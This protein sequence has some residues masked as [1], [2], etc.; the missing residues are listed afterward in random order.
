MLGPMQDDALW[1]AYANTRLLIG[2]AHEIKID[3]RE[4]LSDDLRRLLTHLGLGATFAIVTSFDP[5]GTRAPAMENEARH[6]EMRA[7]LLSRNLKFVPADGES[8]DSAHR[9]RGFAIAMSRGD[10]AALARELEQ[11]ALYW[12]DGEAFWID[13]ALSARAPRKLP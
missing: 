9:E 2:S 13:A 1:S 4:P 11:L 8:P 3:L 5:R 6:I 7:M 12:F 10:A